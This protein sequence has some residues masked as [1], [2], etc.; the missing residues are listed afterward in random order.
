MEQNE[1]A[2]R[3]LEEPPGAPLGTRKMKKICWEDLQKFKVVPGISMA[4]CRANDE[5]AVFELCTSKDGHFYPQGE[6]TV[7]VFDDHPLVTITIS[8]PKDVEAPS[9]LNGLGR[10]ILNIIGRAESS[11]RIYWR[12]FDPQL[13]KSH[14]FISKEESKH[15]FISRVRY[16]DDAEDRKS[17]SANE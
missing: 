11:L 6:A 5:A 2:A 16:V 3:G 13:S 1:P 14:E 8:L 7:F 9:D 15:M 10:R 12:A 17:P 4:G